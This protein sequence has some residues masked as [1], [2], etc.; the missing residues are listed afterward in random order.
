M[1]HRIG[2]AS[3]TGF[4][5]HSPCL[6]KNEW[7]GISLIDDIVNQMADEAVA[8]WYE[9]YGGCDFNIDIGEQHIEVAF[10]IEPA[11]ARDPLKIVIVN[12]NIQHSSFTNGIAWGYYGTDIA[13]TYKRYG[14][15]VR[16]C[17]FTRF[18][19][20]WSEKLR[21]IHKEYGENV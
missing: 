19:E 20:K 18:A 12:S 4:G 17:K 14:E 3:A 2:D 1:R 10:G 13:Q 5:S 11:Y 9:D 21:K 7:T 16:N 6:L 8:L 15:Y